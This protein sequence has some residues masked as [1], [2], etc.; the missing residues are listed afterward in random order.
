[1]AE[2]LCGKLPWTVPGRV[3]EPG[4]TVDADGSAGGGGRLPAEIQSGEAAQR[5]GLRKP[6]GIC[7]AK[8][9]MPHSGRAT[10]SLRGAWTR[11][12]EKHKLKPMLGLTH[13]WS[14][15]LSPVK[16]ELL[17]YCATRRG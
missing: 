4:A 17:F 10:P 12:A 16:A 9:S 13:P 14:R 15:K 3:L 5:A 6:G 11:K 7:G 1:M 2:R 8:L